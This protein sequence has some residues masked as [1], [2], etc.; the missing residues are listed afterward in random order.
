M[1]TTPAPS[2]S[3]LPQARL[4]TM[5]PVRDAARARAFCEES[6]GLPTEGRACAPYAVEQAAVAACWALAA[7]IFT[8]SGS[9]TRFLMAVISARMEI[10]I[11]GG[12]RLPM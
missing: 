6:S 9:A 5:L 11:S 2:P 12:V 1:P 10:A 4:T 3:P 7:A 8:A